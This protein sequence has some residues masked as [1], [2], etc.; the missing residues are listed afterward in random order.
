MIEEA[1][2]KNHK[3]NEYLGIWTVNRNGSSQKR[4][5][6][7]TP[8]NH[9]KLKELDDLVQLTVGLEIIS[10]G[11]FKRNYLSRK[12]NREFSIELDPKN[13]QPID[14]TVYRQY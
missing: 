8:E 4:T 7:F 14:W 13:T 6:I 5:L 9:K 1:E 11:E 10:A 3:T 2:I 12:D